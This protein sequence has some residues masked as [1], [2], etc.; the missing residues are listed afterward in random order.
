MAYV[1]VASRLL[2]VDMAEVEKAI[3]KQFPAKK[4]AADL[5]VAAARAGHEHASK[6]AKK[7]PLRVERMDAN[8]GKIVIDGNSAAALGAMFAGVTVVAW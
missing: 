8:R 6:L 5:N 7:D 2:D 1:G 3:R 4:K